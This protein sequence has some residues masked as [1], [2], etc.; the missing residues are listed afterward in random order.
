[1]FELA[2]RS[3]YID[4]YFPL[5]ELPAPVNEGES[6]FVVAFSYDLMPAHTKRKTHGRVYAT[7]G[8]VDEGVANIF[9]T[10]ADWVG[11]ASGGPI[12]NSRGALVAL[13][14]GNTS[15]PGNTVT[16][17]FDSKN[18]FNRAVRLDARFLRE[19]ARF[20]EGR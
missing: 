1:M 10:D 20:V 13:V 17:R 11:L 8:T 7:F 2:D 18:D 9:H 4:G 19:Y 15:P 14:Q 3:K 5:P 16:R 6:V 12:Y